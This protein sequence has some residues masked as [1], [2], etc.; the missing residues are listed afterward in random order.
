MRRAWASLQEVGEFAILRPHLVTA[1]K[2]NDEAPLWD[3][4]LFCFWPET[5]RLLPNSPHS[6]ERGSLHE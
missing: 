1:E 2:Q 6:T 3:L 4:A 5:G